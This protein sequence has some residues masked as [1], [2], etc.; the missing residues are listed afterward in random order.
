MKFKILFLC[1]VLILGYS[2]LESLYIDYQI[3]VQGVGYFIN[4][5]EALGVSTNGY[6]IRDE[7]LKRISESTYSDD[8]KNLFIKVAQDMQRIIMNSNNKEWISSN[9]LSIFQ[10]QDCQ[11]LIEKSHD[12]SDT[13]TIFRQ[14]NNSLERK[15]F[16]KEFENNY[17]QSGKNLV[18]PEFSLEN[19]LHKL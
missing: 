11:I 9:V 7:D 5:S 4:R 14:Y 15:F 3:K 18:M 2:F 10:R 19:C 16:Y 8:E 13:T 17:Y 1:L 12:N 6:Q